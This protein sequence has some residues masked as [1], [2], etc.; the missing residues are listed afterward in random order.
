MLSNS[1]PNLNMFGAKHDFEIDFHENVAAEIARSASLSL[2]A[3]PGRAAIVA[4]EIQIKDNMLGAEHCS[5]FLE[6]QQ[7][8]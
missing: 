1:F 7:N 5:I 4:P 6:L 3:V 2:K 8:K